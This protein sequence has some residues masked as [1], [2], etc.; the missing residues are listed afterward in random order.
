[1]GG[2]IVL[3]IE[4]THNCHGNLVTMPLDLSITTPPELDSGQL[5]GDPEQLLLLGRKC[6]KTRLVS[7]AEK[8]FLLA[9]A[10]NPSLTT[11]HYWL[12]YLYSRQGHYEQASIELK[13]C[14]A[15][16]PRNGQAYAELGLVYFK[17]GHI[18]EARALWQQGLWLTSSSDQSLTELLEH[19][20]FY[21]TL[22][23]EVKVVANLC[24]M[25][26]LLAE[27]DVTLACSYLERARTLEPFN[28]IVFMAIATVF[29]SAGRNEDA[30]RAWQEAIRL[31]PQDPEIKAKLAE[32]YLNQG[33][34]NKARSW[35]TKIVVMEPNNASYH[36]L[37]ARIEASLKHIKQA[38]QHLIIAHQLE[39]ANV[40]IN[41]EL[42]NLLWHC[43]HNP[44]AVVFLGKAA[45]A[46]H[47]EAKA[48]LSEIN[49]V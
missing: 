48:L 1:M 24:R 20:S 8:C 14:L 49:K 43:Y 18:R 11:A 15:A 26:V 42:G 12:G 2:G 41:F 45:R 17:M 39:P 25:A 40:D 29:T 23:G 44:T 3:V 31:R 27:K 32:S 30:D 46:G 9:V 5:P 4:F 28:P 36:L 13:T 21:V 35:A 37:L 33:K 34:S 10:K 6:L 19:M 16:Q 22:D 7:E 47:K 38:E